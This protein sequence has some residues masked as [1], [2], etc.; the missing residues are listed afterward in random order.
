M[1]HAN[2][3]QRAGLFSWRTLAIIMVG[4]FA[5]Q[6]I[7]FA[8]TVDTLT[9]RLDEIRSIAEMQGGWVYFDLSE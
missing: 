1:R 5:A 4:G 3:K 9:D 8:L 6:L 2:C 7:T